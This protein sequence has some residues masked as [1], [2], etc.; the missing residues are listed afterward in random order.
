MRELIPVIL[1]ERIVLPMSTRETNTSTPIYDQPSPN[2]LREVTSSI[3]IA[4]IM[5]FVFRAFIIEA[6]VIPTGSMA[7]T[8]M[9]AH[10]EFKGPE[11]GYDWT[12]GPTE[13][14]P[15]TQTPKPV[16]GRVDTQ[17]PMTA[18]P[19]HYAQVPLLAGDRI[20]V[21]KYLFSIHDPERFDVV[22]FKSP[23]EPQTNFIKRLIGLPGEQVALIDGD[24]F[25]RDNAL[26]PPATDQRIA[27]VDAWSQDGWHIVRKNERTQRGI[28]QDVFDSA[29]APDDPAWRTPAWLTD[30][31]PQW[32]TD[33][34][35]SYTFQGSGR[36]TL[37]WNTDQRPIVD[38]YPYNALQN[39]RQR[40]GRID[41]FFP[42]SDLAMS[43]NIKP[44]KSTDAL[45][46]S[47]LLQARG[48]EF[49]AQIQGAQA[50]LLMRPQA[51]LKDVQ[52]HWTTLASETIKNAFA[53]GKITRIDFWHV[54]Q[55]LWLWINDKL[56]AKAPYEWDPAQRVLAATGRSIEQMIDS[57]STSRTAFSVARFYRKPK[58]QWTFKGGSFELSRVA[59][60]RDLYYQSPHGSVGPYYGTGTHP[61]NVVDLN[62]N[63][64]FVCGDNSPAS[65]DGRLW[66]STSPWIWSIDK[67]PGIVPRNLMIGRAFFVYFPALHKNHGVPVPSFGK[68]RF[69]W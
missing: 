16:Q 47:A 68:I 12:V 25:V 34:N 45:W 30:D 49:S 66:T 38:T 67:T 65:A 3:L 18:Q 40:N 1:I 29:Y 24:V 51:M 52:A 39:Q 57:D 41:A 60:K 42:V 43:C 17:D 11:S 8:L 59:L 21:L 54:D 4:F 33:H 31:Q 15:R 46:V 6:F 2:P 13:Y 36:A 61:Y 32:S 37:T 48:Y 20:L 23:A 7:P 56:V 14:F 28:W 10:M 69:I 5:A 19:L 64:F 63:Q 53:P 9:G 35:A 26:A 62:Q 50:R 55:Q 27:R 22:V 44:D 58:P